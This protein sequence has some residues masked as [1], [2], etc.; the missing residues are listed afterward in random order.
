MK[1]LTSVILLILF[2]LVAQAQTAREEIKANRQLSANNYYA[3]PTP[4]AKLKAAP[5]GYEPFYISTYARHGSRYLIDPNDYFFPKQVLLQADSLNKLTPTGK[6]VLNIVLKMS[7]M[8]DGRLGELTPLGARQHRGIAKRMY[9]NFPQ[10][11]ADSIEID[12][13]STIVIRCILSMTA[14]CLQLQAMNPNLKIK[15]DASNHDMFYMNHKD[16]NLDKLVKSE[17]VKNAMKDFEANHVHPSRL[18]HILFIDDE[19][20]KSNVDTIQ[21][22]RR[23]FDLAA[24]MQSHDTDMELYSLFTDDE[25]YDL[26]SCNNVNWFL[27]SGCSPLTQCLMPYREAELLRNILDTTD[28]ALK[29]GKRRATL[30]F[31]HESCVLPLVTL[32]ELNHY[33][34]SYPDLEKLSEQWRAYEVFPMACNVQFIFFHKK[35]SADILVKVLLNEQEM[36]LPFKSDL[37]PYYHWKDVASYYRNKLAKY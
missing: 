22:M 14:E 20:V 3:Y 31:G 12:A 19:Y 32:L 18:M 7:D 17:E 4:T 8:A 13:R 2:V 26:W 16:K 24:N 5:K 1:R 28:D 33:G 34:R 29:D 15:N 35:G 11:F 6:S 30:R 37:V 21:L 10:I 9:T 36:Q 25:C 23:L 27:N